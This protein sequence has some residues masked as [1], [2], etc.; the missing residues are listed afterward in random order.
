[1]TRKDYILLAKTMRNTV[2]DL[3]YDAGQ[4]DGAM[5]SAYAIANALQSD[6]KAFNHEHFM[7]VVRG[8]KELNSRPA[9][10]AKTSE[11]EVN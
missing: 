2:E 11:S 6:N 1:M 5:A 10:S 3:R 8:E 7:A 4:C 9:K